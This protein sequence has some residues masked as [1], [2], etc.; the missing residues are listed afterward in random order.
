MRITMI[1]IM[2]TVTVIITIITTM[3]IVILH[4]FWFFVIIPLHR[5]W[6]LFFPSRPDPLW[7]TVPPHSRICDQSGPNFFSS[8]FFMFSSLY[9]WKRNIVM[10]ACIRT[11]TCYSGSTFYVMSD[12]DMVH[13]LSERYRC[14]TDL[15]KWVWR[16]L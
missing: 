15:N 2:K 3:I 1:I 6:V 7:D 14:L 4:T 16:L 12:S 5:F 8:S 9:N 11:P 13:I 10:Y